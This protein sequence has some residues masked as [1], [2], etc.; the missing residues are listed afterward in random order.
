MCL[1]Y[2]AYSEHHSAFNLANWLKA[3]LADFQIADKTSVLNSDTVANMKG[4]LF[5]FWNL[6]VFYLYIL[7]HIRNIKT[8]IMNA[9]HFTKN[10]KFQLKS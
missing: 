2:H 9:K 7:N 10:A 8:L 4:D 1:G 3:I 5:I 6:S